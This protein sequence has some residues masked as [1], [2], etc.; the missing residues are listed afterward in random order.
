MA[1]QTPLPERLGEHID[2]HKRN[3]F[4]EMNQFIRSDP[5]ITKKCR[6]K[7]RKTSFD[8]RAPIFNETYISKQYC[9]DKLL[10]EELIKYNVFNDYVYK[11]LL[12]PL[13]Q[14]LKNIL[15]YQYTLYCVEYKLK[16]RSFSPTTLLQIN[17]FRCDIGHSLQ[18]DS[19]IMMVQIHYDTNLPHPYLV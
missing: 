11:L 10:I 14:Q 18:D 17:N 13:A 16:C 4:Y 2:N 15:L 19:Y 1:M 6:I 12:V 7:S 8:N 3:F 5:F 9:F